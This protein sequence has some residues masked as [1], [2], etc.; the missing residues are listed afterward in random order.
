MSVMD[1]MHCMLLGIVKNLWFYTWI[2]GTKALRANTDARDHELSYIHQLLHDMDA[3]PWVGRLP[4]YVGEP[5][6]GNLSSDEYKV[7]ST[8]VGPVILPVLWWELNHEIDAEQERT[9]RSYEK[10]LSK[11]NEECEKAV[12]A[13]KRNQTAASARTAFKDKHPPPKEPPLPCRVCEEVPMFLALA[14]AFLLLL[15]R[16]LTE[17]DRL[18]GHRLLTQHLSD[19]CKLYGGQFLKP[20][21]HWCTHIADQI[22]DY[23]PVYVFWAFHAERL[24]KTLK[25]FNTNNHRGGVLEVSMICT[26]HQCQWTKRMLSEASNS[27]E[28]PS[29]LELLHAYAQDRRQVHGTVDVTSHAPSQLSHDTAS[30]LMVVEDSILQSTVGPADAHPTQLKPDISAALAAWYRSQSARVY[31]VYDACDYDDS[32]VF[33]TPSATFH[34]FALLDGWRIIPI[35]PQFNLQY[36]KPN[37]YEPIRVL[38]LSSV[39]CQLARIHYT[40]PDIWMTISLDKHLI[41]YRSTLQDDADE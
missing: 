20:N 34:S 23:G 33:V 37:E 36:W 26:L 4:K 6:G 1:P 7:L 29:E 40:N 14:A 12:K 18:E 25:S 21:H 22:L 5:R 17:A 2:R 19:F 30:H 8:I 3:P 35:D 27:A 10:K 28:N 41:N 11:Y 16:L 31:S 39:I 13:K 24:N 15:T 32:W 9:R 38:P